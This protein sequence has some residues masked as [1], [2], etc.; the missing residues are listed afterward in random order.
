MCNS[1]DSVIIILQMHYHD[2]MI[3]CDYREHE[4]CSFISTI[5]LFMNT[6]LIVEASFTY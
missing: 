5:I 1:I 3:A 6:A 4:L 2:M